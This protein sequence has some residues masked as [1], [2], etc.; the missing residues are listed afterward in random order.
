MIAEELHQQADQQA[1]GSA[2]Q[3][4]EEAYIQTKRLCRIFPKPLRAH[5][6]EGNKGKG[7]QGADHAQHDDERHEFEVGCGFGLWVDH[8]EAS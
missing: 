2:D 6:N 1:A 7:D 8:G 5:L 4:R 3:H